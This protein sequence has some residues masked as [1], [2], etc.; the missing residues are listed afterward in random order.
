MMFELGQIIA[1]QAVYQILSKESISL[2][3]M[4]YLNG[5]W[6]DMD[7]HDKVANDEA[8]QHNE[9]IVASYIIDDEKIFIITEAD[10]SAT[11]LM[12]AYEY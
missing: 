7:K 10:R 8:I 4:R 1:T 2:L 5:D 12:F 3:L 9:R 6:G 11:T